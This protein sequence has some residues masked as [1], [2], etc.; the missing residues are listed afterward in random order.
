MTYKN[1]TK[2]ILITVFTIVFLSFL[3]EWLHFDFKPTKGDLTRI[4]MHSESDYDNN[5][6]EYYFNPIL[7]S[8]GSID[9]IDSYD[10][11]VIGDSFSTRRFSRAWHHYLQ[12][13]VGL[14][15]GVFDISKYS[16]DDI[17]DNKKY[18]ESPPKILIYESIER[19]L[20]ER[21]H[22][23]FSREQ[24][25]KISKISLRT[26]LEI[27][28]IVAEPHPI[29][30]YTGIFFK[31]DRGMRYLK[32]LFRRTKKTKIL[33]LSTAELFTNH[34][35]SELLIFHEDIKKKKNLTLSDWRRVR[36]DLLILQN[37]VQSNG[38]TKFIALIAPDKMTVYSPY[39]KDNQ[40]KGISQY[41]YLMEDERL[42]IVPLLS[43][44]QEAHK[45]NKK[46]IYLPNDTHWSSVG[47]K[48]VGH[49][50]FDYLKHNRIDN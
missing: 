38:K 37:K 42:N 7:S 13:E 33:D 4:G 11:I 28:P 1:Y 39:L 46:D 43:Y 40:W 27:N 20:P 25:Q 35:S 18:K 2:L 29:K 47:N 36:C 30:Q 32:N 8:K 45:E 44:F 21:S 12:R 3:V 14:H 15:I 48:L 17:I 16:L 9:K 22:S 10:I 41:Q 26:L 5:G 31:I 34:R 19:N 6:V 23:R 50:V 49:A 24:C